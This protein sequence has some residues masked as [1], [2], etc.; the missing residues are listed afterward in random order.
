[1][2]PR[3]A[4]CAEKF[5]P[6]GGAPATVKARTRA[7]ARGMILS[8]CMFWSMA[9]ASAVLTLCTGSHNG[10]P[11]FPR[12]N[13]RQIA[14]N[15]KGIWFLAHDGAAGG[16]PAIH[17]SVS[18]GAEPEFAG[19]FHSSVV[20]AGGSSQSVLTGPFRGARTASLVIDRDD[21]LH[22]VFQSSEPEGIWYAKCPV[23]DENPSRS[24]GT[25][26]K[27][28]GA[29][30]GTPGPER[31]DRGEGAQLG[32]LVA[33]AE[34]RPWVLYSRIVQSSSGNVY[35][36]QDKGHQYSRRARQPGRQL[37]AASPRDGE[38]IRRPLTRPGDFG[39]P[40]ADL[41]RFGTLHLTSSKEGFN[42]LFYLQFPNFV[43]EFGRQYDFAAT[44]PWVPWNGTGFV[45]HSVIGWGRKALVAWE[46]VEHQILYAFFDGETWS[47]QALH[48]GQDHTHHPILVGDRHDVG[49]VFWTNTTRSHTFYSRWL[50]SRFGAQ[51][52]GRT[53][54]GD[55]VSHEAA[56]RAPSLS[57]FHTVGRGRGK[58]AGTLGMALATRGP[59]GGVYFDGLKVPDL[60]PAP[61]RRVLFLDMQ[62]VSG[63]DGLKRS[64]HP[65]RK[66]PA[67]PVLRTGPAGSWDDGRAIAY[68]E[69][70]LDD[71]RFRMWYSGT[72]RASL[73]GRISGGYRVGYAESED[74]IRWAKPVLNQVEY[75]GSNENNIVD[76]AYR[77]SGHWA[78]VVK[79]EREP[80]SEQRYKAL[81]DHTGGN[82]LHYSAD[83]YRWTE[84]VLVN[85]D[86]L[87]EGGTNPGRFG[88]RRN[89]FHD[90]LE[91]D[92]ERR[93]K[94]FGRHCFGTGLLSPRYTRRTCRYWS[95]D[96]IRWT[97]DPQNPILQPRAGSEVE[98][99]AMSVWIEGQLYVGLFDAWD[100]LQLSPQQLAMSRDGRHFVHVFDGVPAV[101]LGPPGTWDAGW[102]SP[103]DLPIRVDD[104]LWLYYSGSPVS[105][106]PLHDWIDLPMETGLATIRQDGW[107]SLEVAEG[108]DSGWFTTIPLTGDSHPPDLEVNA[109]GLSG[110]AGRIAVELIGARKVLATGEGLNQDGVAVPVRWTSSQ[111]IQRPLPGTLRLRFRL[112]GQAR[113]YGFTFR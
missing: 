87:P 97:R 14:N 12:T 9:D 2:I 70:L 28:T 23:G 38:W 64:F 83:G 10:V 104:E 5:I 44:A 65:M 93:W 30:G 94:V 63:L 72:D 16:A 35:T 55:P 69:V 31:F 1:M 92:P 74:G 113:L 102:I 56:T 53:A 22:L 57:H 40:A 6:A 43:E 86:R 95:P 108:K 48:P 4:E 41:D 15:S 68:G 73:K 39:A 85:P 25:R 66:H 62:E 20:V 78:M 61:G 106:G 100:A 107:V 89:L 79:D 46:K 101:A 51:Y 90:E 26:N 80:D 105:I 103:A 75:R 47:V 21:V 11:P 42:H 110:D 71:G 76:F 36:V 58:H 33:D 112:A 88:D 81:V 18:K 27:W 17:L 24:L 59:D 84:G 3:C 77:P 34:G 52:E 98:Q 96:L 45:S 32:D 60:K 111:G 13:G 54:G 109:E 49:W 82:R 99:H 91:T 19:D 37:W 29:D 67:N 50:G 8:I 7:C